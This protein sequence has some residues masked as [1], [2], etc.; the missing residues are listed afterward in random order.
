MNTQ[1]FL[2]LVDELLEVEP[3]TVRIE[4]RLEAHGWSSLS[5]VAFIA[6]ADEKLGASIAP[7]RLACCESVSDLRA[8]VADY[9][10]D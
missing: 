8:C 10:S 5:R 9:L 1:D 2:K 4:D 7:G 6:L 3:G